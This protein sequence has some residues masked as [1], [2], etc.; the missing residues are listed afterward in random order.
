MRLEPD[1]DL[2]SLVDHAHDERY[3]KSDVLLTTDNIAPELLLLLTDQPVTA[4]AADRPCQLYDYHAPQPS[5]TQG[6]HRK[7]V[8][9]QRRLYGR[10]VDDELFW[11]CGLCHDSVHDWVSWLL[12]EARKPDPVPGYK[13]RAEARRTFEWYVLARAGEQ[14]VLLPAPAES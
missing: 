1:V 11:L 7:P 12:G 9:L 14:G 5:R 13:A 10:V 6:H 4:N 2:G 3:R 8:Y